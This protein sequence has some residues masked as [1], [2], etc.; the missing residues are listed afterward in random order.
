MRP[1]TLLGCRRRTGANG[2]P[3]TA[4][5]GVWLA[6]QEAAR[7]LTSPRA[8]QIAASY[9]PQIYG[10]R[11][12]RSAS[13]A[14]MLREAASRRGGDVA[15]PR[16][17]LGL[18]PAAPKQ[19]VGHGPGEPDATEVASQQ[20]DLLGKLATAPPLS[21]RKPLQPRAAQPAEPWMASD[22][23]FAAVAEDGRP[24]TVQGS[25]RR[26]PMQPSIH[27]PRVA[28]ADCSNRPWT[29]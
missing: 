10:R 17:T 22:P 1:L 6:R 23:Y 18:V 28:A 29:K 27:V 2:R 19:T 12:P 7:P 13:D 4:I 3:K 21:P 20:M 11:K 8:S 15:S 26:G 9:P 16:E 14:A 24:S 25:A 5:E